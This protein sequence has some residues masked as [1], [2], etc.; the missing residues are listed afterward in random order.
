MVD[1]SD[2][3]VYVPMLL[4]H[5]IGLPKSSM[6]TE[7]GW[8]HLLWDVSAKLLLILRDLTWPAWGG[9]ITLGRPWLIPPQ[10]YSFTT[11]SCACSIF[12]STVSR[13]ATTL[14]VINANH[15]H[16]CCSLI[17]AEAMRTRRTSLLPAASL[18]TARAPSHW[19][20]PLAVCRAEPR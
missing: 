20:C 4:L 18:S 6:G 16:T 1:R 3:A 19:L 10:T 8:E 14:P 7:R 5:K 12:N 13:R 9:V 2:Q 15:H 11:L 17:F